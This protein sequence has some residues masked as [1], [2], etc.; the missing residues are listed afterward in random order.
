MSFL[1]KPPRQQP[2]RAQLVHRSARSQWL[3]SLTPGIRLRRAIEPYM[4]DDSCPAQLNARATKTNSALTAA[5]QQTGGR[6][7]DSSLLVG[8]QLD[9]PLTLIEW[10]VRRH[11]SPP[12]A[13]SPTPLP[14]PPPPVQNDEDNLRLIP[15]G[16]RPR[17]GCYIHRTHESHFLHILIELFDHSS[18][19]FTFES[20]VVR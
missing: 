17:R 1:P 20:L 16:W 14:V 12:L 7:R 5:H 8:W 9:T 11:T 13:T 4:T 2:F 10:Y 15:N 6:G 19:A 3:P 18:S